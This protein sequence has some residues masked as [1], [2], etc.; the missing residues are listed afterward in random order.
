MYTDDTTFGESVHKCPQNVIKIHSQ[1]TPHPS[2]STTHLCRL[3]IAV[4]NDGFSSIPSNRQLFRSVGGFL[5]SPL[6][7]LGTRPHFMVWR[8]RSS[9][10]S[11]GVGNGSSLPLLG[12]DSE[13]AFWM[14]FCWLET[15]T[16]LHVQTLYNVLFD[17]R[18]GCVRE[19]MKTFYWGGKDW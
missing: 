9:V 8:T 6:C 5:G 3:W 17:Y 10:E 15:R 2:A 19:S 12:V 7:Q 16:G 14:C 11:G 13:M 4:R 1:I 18:E